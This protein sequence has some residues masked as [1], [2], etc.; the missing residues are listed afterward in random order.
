MRSLWSG[1]NIEQNCPFQQLGK[2]WLC[3]K[4]L[5]TW[6]IH[7]QCFQIIW[8]SV[9]PF[10]SDIFTTTKFQIGPRYQWRTGKPYTIQS[11]RTHLLEAR[12]FE[13]DYDQPTKNDCQIISEWIFGRIS[14]GH[15]ENPFGPIQFSFCWNIRTKTTPSISA[16][17]PWGRYKPCFGSTES[18]RSF[19]GIYPNFSLIQIFF[20]AHTGIHVF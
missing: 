19:P 11:L 2:L 1:V 6:C 13:I 5:S 12:V 8:T 4:R 20:L 15:S 9:I 7:L 16:Y 3:Q 10:C 14:L 17:H 18:V